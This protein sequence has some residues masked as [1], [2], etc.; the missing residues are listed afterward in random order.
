MSNKGF[1]VLGPIPA[2][3]LLNLGRP[4]I[5]SK[6]KQKRIE[7]SDPLLGPRG[8]E[9]LH[10]TVRTGNGSVSRCLTA[11]VDEKTCPIPFHI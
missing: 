9:L 2:P 7:V 6:R 1:G 3:D 5:N 10:A 4:L 8:I 11:K